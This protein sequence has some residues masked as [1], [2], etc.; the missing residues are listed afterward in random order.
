[1]RTL[2]ASGFRY[3]F[4]RSSVRPYLSAPGSGPARPG[5]ATG[6]NYDRL[7]MMMTMMLMLIKRGRPA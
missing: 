2:L 6:A 1:M 3:L 7:M 5:P 4:C